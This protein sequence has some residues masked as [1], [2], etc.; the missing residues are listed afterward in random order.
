MYVVLAPFALLRLTL[1]PAFALTKPI[2]MVAWFDWSIKK[3]FW[4]AEYKDATLSCVLLLVRLILIR[5]QETFFSGARTSSYQVPTNYDWKWINKQA[6]FRET[7][8]L[9]YHSGIYVRHSRCCLTCRW[10][11]LSLNISTKSAQNCD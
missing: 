9:T 8:L 4:V 5:A 1:K 10:C 3:P 11:R 7:F 6:F 2:L